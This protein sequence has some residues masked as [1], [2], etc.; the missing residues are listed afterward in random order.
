MIRN[1]V[2]VYSTNKKHVT[3]MSS[4]YKTQNVS[5]MKIVCTL[6]RAKR[7]RCYDVNR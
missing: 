7:K 5:L 2:E 4:L 3:G 6:F 1:V